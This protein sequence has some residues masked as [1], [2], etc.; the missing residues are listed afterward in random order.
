MPTLYRRPPS[1]PVA[2][3][4]ADAVQDALDEIVIEHEVSNVSSE[5]D[6]PEGVSVSMQDLPVLVDDGTAYTDPPA[7]RQHLD[8]LRQLMADWNR[9]QS[10][11]CH[12]NDDGTVCGPYDVDNMDGPG[13]TAKPF[14]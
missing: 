8:E 12:I 3:A 1:T 5:A 10:D 11:T 9:F 13:I 2:T 6:L 4:F 14:R 7:I